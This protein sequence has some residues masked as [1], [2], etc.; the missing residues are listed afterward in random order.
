VKWRLSGLGLLSGTVAGVR[1]DGKPVGDDMF[2]GINVAGASLARQHGR[3]VTIGAGG[4]VAID[5]D[6][7]AFRIERPDPCRLIGLRV[8]R[9]TIRFRAAGASRGPLRVVQAGT[10]ALRLLAGYVRSLLTGDAPS[11]AQLAAAVVTHLTELIELSL[12]PAGCAG[13]PGAA[14]SVR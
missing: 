4:A 8:S 14:D 7:G 11:S 9:S 1:Q 5:P 2:F 12:D 13:L 6:D 3:E 10:P